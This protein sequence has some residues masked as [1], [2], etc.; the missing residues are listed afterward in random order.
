MNPY[1]YVHL[2]FDKEAKTIQWG[3]KSAFS[4]NG[5]CSTGGL[6]VEE[7]KLIHSYPPVQ[8]SSPGVK[9]CPIKPDTLNL[10]EEKV[11]KSLE[12]MSTEENFLN[13]TRMA[14]A[15]RSRINKW[16]IIKCKVSVR[17]RTLSIGQNG[18]QQIGKR[19][20]PTLHLLEG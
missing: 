16:D 19:T 7:C 11:G 9:D 8:S 6:H 2:I 12:H 5:A 10:I 1:T 20:L 14:Y 18:S 17:Q 3:K 4:T 15:L 13:K